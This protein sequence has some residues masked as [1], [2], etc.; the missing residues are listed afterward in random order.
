MGELARRSPG[1]MEKPKADNSKSQF[2]QETWPR[3]NKDLLL[4]K[5]VEFMERQGFPPPEVREQLEKE[6]QLLSSLFGD[7]NTGL[8]RDLL[9]HGTGKSKYAGEKY[10][11]GVINEEV[12]PVLATVLEEGLVPHHDPWA[13]EGEM[14]SISAAKNYFYSKYYADKYESKP[15]E[16]SWQFGD[17]KDWLYYFMFDIAKSAKFQDAMAYLKTKVKRKLQKDQVDINKLAQWTSSLRDDIGGATT[18]KDLIEGHS[19]I[20]GNFGAVL[21]IESAGLPVSH[22]KIIGAHEVRMGQVVL[23][24]KIKAIGVP[25]VHVN[26]AKEMLHNAQLHT[27]VFSLECADVYLSQFPLDQLTER[28]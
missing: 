27:S 15:E 3:R 17:P 6:R 8:K 13:R 2:L 10:R 12:V 14:T 19:T 5:I 24:D 9:F 16:M 23:P 21:C 1:F 25:M 4:Q 26:E 28:F 22:P 20:N 18:F 7:S 11:G